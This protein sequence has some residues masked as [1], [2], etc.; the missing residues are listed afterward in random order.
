MTPGFEGSFL[1]AADKISPAAIMEC[2]ICWTIY[3]PAEGDETRQISPGTAFLDLPDDW[4]CPGC[5]APAAQFLVHADPDAPSAALRAEMD[6]RTRDLVADFTDVFH[7]R[8]RDLPMVN[9]ALHVQAVGFQPFGGGFLGI[10][11]APWFMNLVLLP[12]PDRV[13]LKAGAKEV[14]SFPRVSTSSCMPAAPCRGGYLACALFSP[15]WGFH[16]SVAGCGCGARRDGG[17]FQAREPR[18]HGPACRDP[19]P[20]RSGTCPFAR[21]Y[22]AP[23][24][25][26]LI[27]GGLGT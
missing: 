1:G 25:R 26:D 27:T 18:G 14:L 24:R 12:G 15:M 5:S 4:T 13:T 22:P 3:D 11:I 17:T 9:Q 23:S 20:P 21:S 10:L 16:Q 19:R 6:A 8:M 7:S 2:K